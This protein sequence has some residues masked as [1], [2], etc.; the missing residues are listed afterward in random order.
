MFCCA[1][2]LQMLAWCVSLMYICKGAAIVDL[3]SIAIQLNLSIC[4]SSW[5]VQVGYKAAILGT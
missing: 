4:L 3:Y 2:C 1:A 5:L